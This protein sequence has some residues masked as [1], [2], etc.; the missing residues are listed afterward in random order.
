MMSTG[1]KKSSLDR[2]FAS[3]DPQS[4]T[5]E[6]IQTDIENRA[7]V[8]EGE[9]ACPI[10]GKRMTADKKQGIHIDVCH[11]HGVWLDKGELAAV[12]GRIKDQAVT[13][14]LA[15]AGDSGEESG[16][17]LGYALGKSL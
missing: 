5:A 8:P 12:I 15:K 17:L 1:D 4:G 10:C 16:F 11:D 14:A 9:R 2:F 6:D 13:D 3:V 7:V